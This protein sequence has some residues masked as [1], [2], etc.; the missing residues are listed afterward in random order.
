MKTF[1]FLLEFGVS[2]IFPECFEKF[3]NFKYKG[4]NEKKLAQ[5]A[6]NA[7]KIM[8]AK[9]GHYTGDSAKDKEI[10]NGVVKWRALNL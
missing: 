3:K 9:T 10:F 6:L 5:D 8:A 7:M 4:K 1:K 2:W